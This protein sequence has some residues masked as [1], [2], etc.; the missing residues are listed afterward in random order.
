VTVSQVGNIGFKQHCNGSV[1]ASNCSNGAW[2]SQVPKPIECHSIHSS[3]SYMHSWNPC[4]SRRLAPTREA[5][6]FPQSVREAIV[7]PQSASRIENLNFQGMRA[8]IEEIIEKL[9]STHPSCLSQSMNGTKSS[10]QSTTQATAQ[11]S[12]ALRKRRNPLAKW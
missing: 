12:H 5:I 8:V 7:F 6:V 4:E 9:D 11:L 10:V 1:S 2:L 3:V